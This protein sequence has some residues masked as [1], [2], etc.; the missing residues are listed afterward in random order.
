MTTGKTIALTRRTLVGKVM[1]LLLNMLSRLVINFLPR[2]KQSFNFMAAINM[3]NFKRN[4]QTF[5]NWL[6]H[7]VFPPA[8]Y[9][10]S[11]SFAF[12]ST[13]GIVSPF[14]V[15]HSMLSVNWYHIVVLI[16]ICLMT[17]IIDRLFICLLVILLPSL[18][19]YLFKY[20]D[21]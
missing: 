18:G 5:P 7:F 8:V 2:S 17:N 10:G 11:T 12:Y 19:K 20:F 9:R 16:C 4:Y 1:S 13:F 14:N 21:H 6:Y 15:K 3:F